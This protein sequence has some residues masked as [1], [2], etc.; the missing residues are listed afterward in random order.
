MKNTLFSLILVAGL[1]IIDINGINPAY[2]ITPELPFR[3]GEKMTFQIRWLSII[4]GEATIELLP[5]E[6]RENEDSNHFLFTARTSEFAD[7]FYKVRDRIESYTDSSMTHSL[8]YTETHKGKSRKQSAVD[9]DWVRQEA[10]YSR[11]G[12]VKERQPVSI[13]PGTFDPL[14]V[15]YAFRLCDMYEESEIILPATDGKKIVQGK[16]SVIRKETIKVNG[17]RYD[18]FLVEPELGDLGG[19]FDKS[20]DAKLQLWVTA[21]KRRIPV[22]MKSKVAVGSFVAEISSYYAG[23]PTEDIDSSAVTSTQLT[24][25]PPSNEPQNDTAYP[26]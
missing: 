9:F 3:I 23:T 25:M 13:V 16:L 6:R 19:V 18:T 22:R 21:D 5:T 2:G 14:S 10:R 8:R 20:E 7:M 26:Q 17:I 11:K 1:V 12:E 15:F 24:V 4:A